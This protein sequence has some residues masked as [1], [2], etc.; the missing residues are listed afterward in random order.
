MISFGP[1]PSRRLGH[2]IGI[3]NIPPKFCSYSCIYC[4]I[5][6]T[7]KMQV[8]RQIFYKPQ[9]VFKSVKNK[10]KES[11]K[12]DET[13]NYLTFVADGEPT[14]DYCLGEEIELFRPLGFKIAVI[15]NSSLI[16]DE[17]VRDDLSKADWVS[18]K[19]DAINQSIWRKINRPHVSIKHQKILEGLIDF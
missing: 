13:I 6:R 7:T 15:T 17:K 5:G 3:N 4:Q 19:I 2:S 16:W 18:V 9:M 12:R 10:I 8:T 1:V 14:L 11:K